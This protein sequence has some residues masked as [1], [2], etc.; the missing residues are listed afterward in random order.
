[1][2]RTIC[3]IMGKKKKKEEWLGASEFI[4]GSE[5]SRVGHSWGLAGLTVAQ[6]F[7][8]KFLFG[9]YIA[10]FRCKKWPAPMEV[11]CQ[12]LKESSPCLY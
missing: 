7:P 12:I 9:F 3:V 11:N 6:L 10:C 8:A 1:M 2:D 5:I 4:Y